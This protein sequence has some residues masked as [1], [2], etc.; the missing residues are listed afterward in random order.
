MRGQ[1]FIAWRN[2]REGGLAYGYTLGFHEAYGTR[3]VLFERAGSA[4]MAFA[5][6]NTRDPIPMIF[7]TYSAR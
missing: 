2:W 5:V 4:H 3:E 6:E 1:T 7:H